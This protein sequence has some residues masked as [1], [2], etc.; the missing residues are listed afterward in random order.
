MTIQVWLYGFL[1]V[2]GTILP[3][4][5]FIPWVGI[6]GFDLPLFFQQIFSY[7]TGKVFASDLIVSGLAAGTF[8]F[9]EGAKIKLKNLWIPFVLGLTIGVSCGFPLFLMM[10]EIHLNRRKES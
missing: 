10:R 9:Y 8:M 4:S 1:A 2:I 6:H 7:Y 3:L 5:F